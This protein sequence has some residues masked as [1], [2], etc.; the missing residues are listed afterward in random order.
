MTWKIGVDIGGAFTD[1]I[2]LNEET[3]ESRWI[4][5]ESTPQDYS[6]GVINAVKRSELDLKEASY[7]T[8]GQTVVINSIIT[9]DGS[10]VGLL[11]TKDFD[12]L[13]IGRGNRRDLF[14]LKYHKPEPFVPR[15]RTIGIDERIT[16]DGTIRT[17]LNE[18]QVRQGVDRLLQKDVESFVVSF[19]N[20][21]NTP[22]HERKA[23]TIIREELKN[24]GKKPFITLSHEITSE[25]REYERTSTAVLNAYTQ[26]ILHEYLTT[27]EDAFQGMGFNETFYVMLANGGMATSDFAKNYPI[28]TVEGGPTGGIIGATVL[29]NV[30]DEENLLVLDGGSTTTKAG[31]V[32]GRTPKTKTDYY[33]ERDKYNPGYPVRVPVVDIVEIGNGGTSIGWIDEVGDLKVGPKAAGAYPGPACYGKGGKKPTLTDAY[34]ITGYLNPEYLLGGEIQVNLDLAGSAIKPIAEH[35]NISVEEAAFNMMRIANDQAGHVIRVIS[36]KRGL[37]PRDFTLIAHGGSGPMFAPFIASELQIPK[38]VVPTV[39]PGVFNAWGMLAADIKHSKIKTNILTLK[40]EAGNL[41]QLNE[42]FNTLEDNMIQTFKDEGVDPEKVTLVRKG[43]VRYLGQ[44]HTVKIPIMGDKIGE[45][46][47][48][49]INQR[50]HDAHNTQ[51]GFKMEENPTEIVNFH[52]TGYAEEKKP[53]LDEISRKGTKEDAL[54][55]TRDVYFKNGFRS[56]PIFKR[57]TLPMNTEIKGPA[58]IE[59]NTTTIVV[60]GDFTSTIDKYGNAI[61][62][63]RK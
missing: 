41:E 7:I 52:I 8:H 29:G 28:T 58:I 2:A 61:L 38:I 3:G 5:V 4:K 48:N 20:A 51:Y 31:L 34:V 10:T 43:E 46:Q 24:R 35:Y 21:Y 13:Q 56:V 37:D 62:T 57:E 42:T 59:G 63:R 55:E 9:R 39:P 45:E 11:S 22:T 15:S 50:F 17:P 23:G 1:L 36:I 40:A 16:V 44:E 47:L 54:K 30:L 19:I 14:N 25:W 26:P 6:E 32:R 18:D 27:L 60:T 12:I 53:E 49:E 33:I